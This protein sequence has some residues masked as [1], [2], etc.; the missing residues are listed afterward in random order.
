[1]HASVQIVGVPPTAARA[2][3]VVLAELMLLAGGEQQAH[4]HDLH[5]AVEAGTAIS[6]RLVA[7]GPTSI[8]LQKAVVEVVPTR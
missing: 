2:C 6:V 3:E 8:W 4:R 1:M 5:V 7:D